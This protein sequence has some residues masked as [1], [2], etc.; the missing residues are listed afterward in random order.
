MVIRVTHI[1]R[2]LDNQWKLLHRHADFLLRISARR[3]T[4]SLGQRVR[5]RTER[6]WKCP[7]GA[8]S[9]PP[10]LSGSAPTWASTAI[11]TTW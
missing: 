2:R 4:R 5:L 1:Y 9:H 6:V 8:S 10:G 7:V 11:T 3:S